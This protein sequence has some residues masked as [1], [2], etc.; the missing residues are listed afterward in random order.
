MTKATHKRMTLFP[1]LLV[2]KKKKKN[3]PSL[4]RWDISNEAGS[5]ASTY[6]IYEL[7]LMTRGKRNRMSEAG[8][9]K[10]A[11]RHFHVRLTEGNEEGH[12]EEAHMG[13]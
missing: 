7:I 11:N 4:N 3:T 13:N 10:E 1:S 2:D 9:K 5:S 12:K 8:G 6:L